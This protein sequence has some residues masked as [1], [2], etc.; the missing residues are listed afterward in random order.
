MSA[1]GSNEIEPRGKPPDRIA[2]ILLGSLFTAVPLYGICALVWSSAV[3]SAP[4]L[5]GVGCYVAAIPLTFWLFRNK[6]R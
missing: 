3:S 4:G 6:G 5:V 1:R 2:V